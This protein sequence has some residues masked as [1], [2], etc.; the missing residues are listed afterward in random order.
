MKITVREC[1]AFAPHYN[2]SLIIVTVRFK[3][4]VDSEM[5]MKEKR[6]QVSYSVG[7]VQR[8]ESVAETRTKM[9]RKGS[10]TY[11]SS[12]LGLVLQ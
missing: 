1:V 12:A 9:G 11:I 8:M 7:V 2:I 10:D 5:H 6:G 4:T 3:Y